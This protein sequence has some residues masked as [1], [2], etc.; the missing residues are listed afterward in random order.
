VALLRHG[1]M[2]TIVDRPYAPS[3]LGSFLRDFT[4]GHVRQ[5]DAV[6]TRLLARLHQHTP[7]LAGINGQV[8]IDLDDTMIEVHGYAEQG[9]FSDAARRVSG[10]M[11][12]RAASE[13]L[14]SG[15]GSIYDRQ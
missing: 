15:C 8:L 13:H 2:R 6:A 10:D 3:T 4:F 12:T 1:A 7:V 11:L 9:S 14:P 5:L